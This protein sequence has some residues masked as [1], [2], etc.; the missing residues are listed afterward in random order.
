MAKP[1]MLILVKTVT[2]AAGLDR[3]P[4]RVGEPITFRTGLKLRTLP[5][6]PQQAHALCRAMQ[7]PVWPQQQARDASP[8]PGA[9]QATEITAQNGAESMEKS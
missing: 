4:R 3:K 9:P 6:P 1:V 5:N 7:Q 8:P 2:G